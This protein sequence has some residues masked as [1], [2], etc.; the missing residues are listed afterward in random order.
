MTEPKAPETPRRPRAKRLPEAPALRPGLYLVG[1]F[2]D[3]HDITGDD[4]RGLVADADLAALVGYLGYAQ[5][6]ANQERTAREGSA[7]GIGR[8]VDLRDVDEARPK[9]AEEMRASFIDR[10]LVALNTILPDPAGADPETSVVSESLGTAPVVTRPS[11][12]WD[13]D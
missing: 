11:M 5:L 13:N 3:Q 2:G 9:T 4:W 7:W 12:P 8:P 1:R 6:Q 10:S